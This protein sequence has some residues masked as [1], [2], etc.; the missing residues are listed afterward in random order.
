MKSIQKIIKLFGI[1]GDGGRVY[2]WK[3]MAQ[4]VGEDDL[5]FGEGF[6][7]R[8]VFRQFRHT[9]YLYLF[10]HFWLSWY[11]ITFCVFYSSSINIFKADINR[12]D[13]VSLLRALLS[14]F[15]FSLV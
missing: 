12:W 10:F 11:Y 9:I 13:L 6:G 3:S 4:Q 15:S 8:P 5:L 7:K 14:L 1:I 2:L